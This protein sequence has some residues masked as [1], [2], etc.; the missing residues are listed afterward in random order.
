[1]RLVLKLSKNEGPF[2]E[3]SASVLQCLH[4][5]TF[6]LYVQSDPQCI[7][8]LAWLCLL[9]NLPVGSGGTSGGVPPP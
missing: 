4:C 7:L 5:G 8:I 1:M 2:A 6:C 9:I 3:H